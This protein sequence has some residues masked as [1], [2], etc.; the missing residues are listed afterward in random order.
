M[1]CWPFR[2]ALR[3]ISARG[4]ARFFCANAEYRFDRMWPTYQQPWYYQLP[5]GVATDKDG[6]VYVAD[7][8][9]KRVQKCT[10]SGSVITTW[11]REGTADGEFLWPWAVAVDKEG[12]V[13]VAE[14]GNVFTATQGNNRIQVFSATGDYLR[15]WGST[16]NGDGQV[17]VSHG[18]RC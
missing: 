1:H 4:R 8:K 13:F 2:D 11:G 5:T 9:N 10:A 16:G 7:W 14:A 17:P 15:K 6:N 12:N 3:I 18:R